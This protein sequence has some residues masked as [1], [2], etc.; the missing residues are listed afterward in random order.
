MRKLVVLTL[1]IFLFINHAWS[2][3]FKNIK[4]KG[5]VYDNELKEW[6]PSATVNCLRSKDSSK[7]AIC[8]TD[9]NGAFFFDSLPAGKYSLLVTF[10]GY[11]S[12]LSSV[13]EIVGGEVVDVGNIVL[14]KTGVT[15]SQIEIV[16]KKES[17]RLSR[18]TLEFNAGSFSTRENASLEDLL[19]RLPGVQVDEN[20]DIKVNGEVVK[21]VTVNGRSLFGINGSGVIGKNLQADLIEKIQVIDRDKEH[22][23]T[24]GVSAGGREKVIN[25]TIKERKKRTLNGEFTGGYGTEG[26]FFI[27]NNLSRFDSRQ[28]FMLLGNGDNIND[29]HVSSD[30]IERRWMSG[31]N[32]NNDFSGRIS[33]NISYLMNSSKNNDRKSIVKKNFV[34]DSSFFYT[35]QSRSLNNNIDHGI[36]GQLE[37]RIDSLQKIS[38]VNQIS[39]SKSFQDIRSDFRSEGSLQRELNSGYLMNLNRR[40][41]FAAANMISYSRKFRKEGRSLDVSVSYSYGKDGQGPYNVS[42]SVYRRGNGHISVDSINQ[43]GDYEGGNRQIFFMAS[44]REPIAKNGFFLFTLAEDKTEGRSNRMM[45][46]YDFYTG[47]YDHFNDSLSNSFRSINQH[48][49][50]KIG[51]G[52]KRNRFDYEV[53]VATFLFKLDNANN[54]FGS[55]TLLKKNVL[56]PEAKMGYMFSGKEEIRLYYQKGIQLPGLDQ[57]QPVIDNSN[58]LYVRRG[59]VQLQPAETNNL[60]LNYKM[61]DPVSMHSLSVNFTGIITKNQFVNNVLTDSVGRQII[62]PENVDKAYSFSIIIDKGIPVN[63]KKN[64]LNFGLVYRL[65]NTPGYVDGIERNTRSISFTQT[66]R[67]S[68]TYGKFFDCMA[69]AVLNYDNVKYQG[70]LG[71]NSRYFVAGLSF[72]GELNLPLGIAFGS[73]FNYRFVTGGMTDQNISVFMLNVSLSRF[74]GLRRQ[75]LLKAEGH[76]LLRQ[77]T[78]VS[79]NIGVNYI[80]D[81]R[82]SILEQFFMLRFS[83]FLGK[84]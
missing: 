20:G 34:G 41:L 18:D 77:N 19:K 76:D 67:Y 47:K 54:T 37:F 74:W 52:V 5:R 51:W 82:S 21:A 48:Y 68:Y 16:K 14:A 40:N 45:F 13:R 9:N 66:T 35:E 80:E 8:F 53:S 60:F 25:L 42:N 1:F 26:R 84:R 78:S 63:N 11:Q 39:F 49:L 69:S 56:L 44:Y 23:V 10:V 55:N 64:M 36:S 6:L 70:Q 17:F 2:Q 62:Q 4:I 22:S 61:F 12:S 71:I 75:F 58:P 46:D 81:A 83:Y 28:Q 7:A 43:T 38:F 72:N 32:Y 3:S 24:D 79:R 31:V 59:N 29:G 57:L 15:L 30:G 50:G 65:R 73:D 33:M 27:K